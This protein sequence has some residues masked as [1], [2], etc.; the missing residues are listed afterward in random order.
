MGQLGRLYTPDLYDAAQQGLQD[1]RADFKRKTLQQYVQPALGGDQG[2]LAKIY[3]VDPQAGMQV[4]QQ[5][6]KIKEDSQQQLADFTRTVSALAA[7]GDMQAASDYYRTH[8]GS[9]SQA[10]GMELGPELQ[11]RMLP[12]IQNVAEALNP[13][14]Q[15]PLMNIGNGTVFDPNKREAVY[16][17]PKQEPQLPNS[18]QEVQYYQQHPEALATYQ[19]MH[20]RPASGSAGGR[21]SARF[22]WQYAADGSLEPVKGGPY[23]QSSEA[24]GL[25][26]DAIDNAAWSYIGT[27]KL[28]P[29]GRGKEGVA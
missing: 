27:G 7:K 10:T 11:E 12:H 20:P 25:S 4:Q 16:T 23:D 9:I 1:G 26:G 6:G 14:K 19:K 13:E 28:P 5:Y 2:A 24:Q 15:Q 21:P 18:V 17:A 8:V 3:G 22:G 29:I